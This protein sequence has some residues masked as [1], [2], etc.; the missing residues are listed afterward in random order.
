VRVG[1]VRFGTSG[2]RGVVGD[3]FTFERAR[4]VVRA[5]AEWGRG[6]GRGFVVAHD[7]RL[8]AGRFAED[9]AAVL[10]AA[11][12]TAWRGS[13]PLPTPA[14]AYAVRRRRA[15]GGIVFTASHNPPEYQGLKLLDADGASAAPVVTREIEARARRILA[16]G[17]VPRAEAVARAVELGAPYR[18]A[19]AALLDARLVR[20]AR[21][22]VVY[23]ALHGTGA[24][25]LDRVLADAGLDV[26]GRRLV[27]DPGFGGVAPDPRP[28]HLQGIARELRRLRGARLG[29][30]TDGDADRIAALDERGRVLT[31]ADVL[32]LLVDHAVRSGRARRGVALSWAAGSL[33]ARVARAHGLAVERHPVGFKHLSR[34]LAAGGADLA[35]DESGG[36]ALGAFGPDKDGI[37]AGALL[38][39]CAAVHGGSLAAALAALRRAHGA[40]AWGQLALAREPGVWALAALRAAPP[41]RLAGA[42]VLAVRDVDGVRL[43]LADGFVMLRVSGTEPLAR[44]YAEAPTHALLDRRLRAAARIVARPGPRSG[45]FRRAPESVSGS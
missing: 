4:A 43:E 3:E 23:D 13:G 6:R 11:G 30:A 41:A 18:R 36:F 1:P 2:W 7:T 21:L 28:E 44:V 24:G 38:A 32:A 12:G 37:L 16:R 27:P 26:R 42:K 45:L 5:I 20:A 15:A 19:L 22:V 14:A 33:A 34:A 39:E 17:R 8:L 9:A 10:E 25:F 40:S 31:S 35:G 29:L